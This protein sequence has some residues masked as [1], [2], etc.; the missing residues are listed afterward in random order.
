MAGTSGKRT[1]GELEKRRQR[2]DWEGD[3]LASAVHRAGCAAA[4]ED[5][6]RQDGRPLRIAH[7]KVSA[8]A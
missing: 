3:R 5:F 7:G 4:S 1:F 2:C 8:F 6:R